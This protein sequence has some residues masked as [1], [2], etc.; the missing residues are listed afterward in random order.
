MAL[1]HDAGYMDANGFTGELGGLPAIPGGNG[2]YVSIRDTLLDVGLRVMP[3]PK[4][5]TRDKQDSGG[6][7]RSSGDD[8]GRCP[9]CGARKGD[10]HIAELHKQS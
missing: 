8:I 7:K 6:G 3:G 1:F 5:K 10:P 4:P 2:I 9:V